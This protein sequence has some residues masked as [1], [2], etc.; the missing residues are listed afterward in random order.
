VTLAIMGQLYKVTPFLMWYYR[1]AQGLSAY[2]VPRL[3]APYFPR[4]GVTAFALT[5]S[6]GSLLPAAVLA[7]G[8][9]PARVAAVLFAVGCAVYAAGIAFSWIVAVLVRTPQPSPS[10]SVV[11]PKT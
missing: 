7:G 11:D 4:W 3:A 8:A 10:P 2:D 6:G 1:Y 5:A 9:A